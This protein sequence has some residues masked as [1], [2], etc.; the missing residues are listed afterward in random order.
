[1]T[2]VYYVIYIYIYRVSNG[3]LTSV[4]V[5]VLYSVRFS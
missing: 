4:I 3:G 2:R 1:M 5:S